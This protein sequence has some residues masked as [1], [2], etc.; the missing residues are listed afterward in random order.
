MKYLRQL[1]MILIFSFI[2]CT[3]DRT[4]QIAAGA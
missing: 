1:L 3:D 4:G 2:D